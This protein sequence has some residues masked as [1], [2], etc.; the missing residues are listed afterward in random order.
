[1]NAP[2]RSLAYLLTIARCELIRQ[3]RMKTFFRIMDK[4]PGE[5][6]PEAPLRPPRPRHGAS[7]TLDRK[8]TRLNS[9]HSQTSYAVFCL[10]KTSQIA[11]TLGTAPRPAF[12][13]RTGLPR[14][15]LAA[16]RPQVR[17]RE[18]LLVPCLPALSCPP[19]S[20]APRK[21]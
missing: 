14:L 4:P 15:H 18:S 20:G 1:Q 11:R 2:A 7:P 8:S 21:V 10:K 3:I 6:S 16:R 17:T 19:G 13:H 9:S 12:S 5:A